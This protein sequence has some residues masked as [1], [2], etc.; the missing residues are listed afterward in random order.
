MFSAFGKPLDPT[1][2]HR[3]G[4]TMWG[5]VNVGADALGFDYEFC[6]ERGFGLGLRS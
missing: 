4:H 2:N 1:M 3:E 6:V 5:G